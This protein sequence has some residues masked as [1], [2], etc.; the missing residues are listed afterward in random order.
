MSKFVIAY[1]WDGG[2]NA[3]HQLSVNCLE[4]ESLKKLKEDFED[5]VLNTAAGQYEKSS[6]GTFGKVFCGQAF[7]IEELFCYKYNEIIK[8]TEYFMQKDWGVILPLE[9]WFDYWK[10]NHKDGH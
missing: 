4:Y 2:D 8:N 1:Y 10:E 9:E 5:F 3:D 6:Y 7:N